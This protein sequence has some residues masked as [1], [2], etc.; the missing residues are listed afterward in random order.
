MRW[1]SQLTYFFQPHYGP[2]VD[3]HPTAMTTKDL[4]G[5]KGRQ[6]CKNDNLT[7]ICEPTV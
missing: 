7:A 2:G 1:I 5:G 6:A 3:Q 4:P